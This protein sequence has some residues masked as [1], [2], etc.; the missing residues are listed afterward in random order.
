MLGPIIAAPLAM[1][2]IRVVTPPIVTSRP[3]IFGHGVG[4][5]DSAG[6]V[7]ER[8]GIVAKFGRGRL[9]AGVNFF[10][11]Q[12]RSDDAGRHHQRLLR[13]GAARLGRPR[14]HLPRIGIA[15]VACAR[16]GHAR[17]DRHYS[18]RITRRPLAVDLHRR[19][20]TPDS[21]CTRPPPRPADRT[22]LATNRASHRCASRRS[23][24]R[25]LG[26]L[27]EDEWT[28]SKEFFPQINAD[29]RR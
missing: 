1:P 16:V 18:N 29:G 26:N 8:L 17:V 13:L 6:R 12:H 28:Y 24:H 7:F 9:D 19:R 23:K 15:L 3:Q 11:R 27:V 22:Q 21:W 25:R 14:R 10:H 5:H 2:V 4:R 20:R